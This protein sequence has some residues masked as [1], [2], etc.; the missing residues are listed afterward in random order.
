MATRTVKMPHGETRALVKI[1]S[2]NLETRTIDVSWGEGVRGLR[3]GPIGDTGYGE[4]YEELS[5]E[6]ANVRMGRLK[7]GASVLDSH[8]RYSGLSATLGIVRDAHVDGKEGSATLELSDRADVKGINDDILKGL[9]VNLSVGYNVF[10]Y[11]QVDLVDNIPVL[12]AVDWEPYE[13]SYVTVPFD[14]KAQSRSGDEPLHNCIIVTETKDKK[15][16]PIELA[17]IEAERVATQERHT[18]ELK[19]AREAGAKEILAEERKRSAEI[20]SSVEKAGLSRDFADK[21]I[22]DGVSIDAARGLIIDGLH[23]AKNKTAPVGSSISIERDEKDTSLRAMEEHILCRIAPKENKPTELSQRFRSS[24]VLDLCRSVLTMNGVRHSNFSRS[25]IVNRA[26]H[27]TSDFGTVIGASVKKTLTQKYEGAPADFLFLTQPQPMSDY[28]S[29]MH[30]GLSTGPNLL[31]VKEHGEYKRGTLAEQQEAMSLKKYGRILGLTREAIINDDLGAL[32]NIPSKWALA[33]S[34]L[35][36]D[37]ILA[38]LTGNPIMADGFALFSA[39]HGNLATVGT[40]LDVTNLSLAIA[41]IE[42]Q[43]ALPSPDG[44]P[45]YLRLKAKYLMV[46]PALKTAALQLTTSIDAITY[47]TVNPFSGLEVVSDPSLVGNAWYVIAAP[48]LIDTIALMYLEGEQGP[49]LDERN[50]FDVDGIEYKVRLDTGAKAL[51]ARP[52]YKNPGI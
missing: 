10:R 50:G 32:Q 46:G 9:I 29:L 15:M 40:V 14:P 13:L 21:L 1:K 51:D 16:D 5:M 18:R 26:L 39:Q 49:Q 52:F 44:S 19:D 42:N 43:K 41:A 45:N 3:Y 4:Y 24:S 38:Q 27:T 12:R 2:A 7:A 33:C 6:V 35:I 20:I 25:E 31:E 11:Q 34:N 28:K 17:R 37:L 36:S 22:G 23:E 47:Q 48:G 8:N 30:V